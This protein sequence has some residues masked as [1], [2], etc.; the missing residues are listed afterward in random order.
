MHASDGE[1]LMGVS[2]RSEAK[3]FGIAIDMCEFEEVANEED[4]RWMSN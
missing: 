2:Q 3:T 1:R 4:H